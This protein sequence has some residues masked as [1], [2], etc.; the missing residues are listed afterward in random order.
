MCVCVCVC[1][2][3]HRAHAVL[4]RGKSLIAVIA[5]RS[6]LQRGVG[7]VVAVRGR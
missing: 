6:V 5:V 7:E 2:Y 4:T 1:V 3:K